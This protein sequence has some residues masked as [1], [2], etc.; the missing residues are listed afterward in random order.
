M[1]M[2]IFT[3]KTMLRYHVDSSSAGNNYVILPWEICREGSIGKNLSK[4][5]GICQ[6]L[7]DYNKYVVQ[8]YQNLNKTNITNNKQHQLDKKGRH[9]FGVFF[10]FF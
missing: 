6:L 4:V 9:C 2:V 3:T 7:F 5:S 10:P 8:Q 1:Y